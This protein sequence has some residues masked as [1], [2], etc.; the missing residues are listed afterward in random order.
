MACG[1]YLEKVEEFYKNKDNLRVLNINDAIEFYNIYLY[2]HDVKIQWKR[3]NNNEIEIYRKFSE[4][5]KGFTFK[6]FSGIDDETF[7]AE[8][9]NVCLEYYSDFITLFEKSSLYE[10][11]SKSAFENVFLKKDLYLNYIFKNKKIVARFGKNLCNILL[12]LDNGGEY[13]IRAADCEDNDYVES[14][15]LPECMTSEIKIKILENYVSKSK[16]KDF[17]YISL[18]LDLPLRKQLP[19]PLVIKFVEKKRFFEEEIYTEKKSFANFRIQFI[20]NQSELIIINQTPDIKMDISY[21]LDWIINNTDYPTLLNNFIYM[22]EFADEHMRISLPTMKLN[23]GLLDYLFENK[24][25]RIYSINLIASWM[26]TC[27]LYSLSMYISLLH[28]KKI[29]IEN[30]I[31]WFYSTYLPIEFNIPQIRT[32]ITTEHRTYL[33]KCHEMATNIDVIFKQ[34]Q[35]YKDY[36]NISFEL[37]SVTSR[38]VKFE[39]IESLVKNKYVY[40]YGSIFDK[41]C[42]GMFSDQ[43]ML[44]YVERIKKTYRS[45]Y[46][47]LKN[48]KIYISDY[49]DYLQD[50]IKTLIAFDL[51]EINENKQILLKN[52][53]RVYLLSE[54]DNVGFISFHHFDKQY[55]YEIYDL[56]QIGIVCFENTLLSRQEANYF[57]YYLNDAFS[58]GPKLRNLYAHG[59]EYLNTDEGQH[60]NNYLILLKLMILLIIKINDE[61]EIQSKLKIDENR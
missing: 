60:Y 47:L 12:N 23:S 37:L 43:C 10:R 11:I 19:P 26:E 45:F 56:E 54:L 58:N 31:I 57:N 7:L 22:F 40:G 49:P 46:E 2:F 39:N 29:N 16:I 24:N 18:L 4:E 17:N 6:Y 51:I 25:P 9:S 27:R 36:K 33:E 59:I 28:T 38:P 1:L 35:C 13:I 14:L 55:Q 21:S 53:L 32:H 44:H 8:V 3:W 15:I 20:E 48:E 30:L 61:F 34:F 52:R 5:L 41:L 50:S 42:Y